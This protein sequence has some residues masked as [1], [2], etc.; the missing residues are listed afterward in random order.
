MET[1][2]LLKAY[3]DGNLSEMKKLLG[4]GESSAAA[5]GPLESYLKTQLADL[6]KQLK[7]LVVNPDG[8]AGQSF[9]GLLYLQQN[10]D[11]KCLN[12]LPAHFAGVRD[13]IAYEIAQAGRDLP[14][15]YISMSTG[16]LKY[17]GSLNITNE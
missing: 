11:K 16:L 5:F 15:E 14:E 6:K 7:A 8:P 2:S 17:A 12:A 4:S 10:F 9:K 13:E 1:S 3:Q